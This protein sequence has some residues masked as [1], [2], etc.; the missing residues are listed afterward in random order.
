MSHHQPRTGG[1]A[2]RPGDVGAVPPR[3]QER[4][5][6]QPEPRRAGTF[7]GAATW[8]IARRDL[9]HAF[10]TPLAWLVLAAWTFVTNGAFCLTLSIIGPGGQSQAPLFQISLITASI[11]LLLLAPAITMTSFAQERERGTMLLLQSCPVRDGELVL[12]KFL[13]ALG[14]LGALILATAVQPAVLW[15]ISEL[16]AGQLATAWLGLLLAASFLA[17]LGIWISALVDSSVACYVLTAA[18]ALVLYFG[19]LVLADPGNALWPPLARAAAF[20]G[21]ESRLTPLRQGDLR[22]GDVAWFLAATALLLA[23]ARASLIARRAL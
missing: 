12:G 15:W 22:L 16:P 17:A 7:F 14:I 18:A 19:T 6:A 23:L 21:L 9:V 1:E 2:D 3:Q 20:I 11:A 8:A 10:T 5:A 4:G 13:A